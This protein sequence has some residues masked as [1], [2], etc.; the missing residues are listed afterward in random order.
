MIGLAE[1]APRDLPPKDS[2]R[3]LLEQSGRVCG[4]LH[5]LFHSLWWASGCLLGA[6]DQ[7]RPL[8][9]RV[10][11]A[12]LSCDASLGESRR[13]SIAVSFLQLCS[14]RKRR[15]SGGSAGREPRL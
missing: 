1:K 4:A 6:A 14:V 9:P 8:Q 5:D 13:V 15:P 2:G 12:G 7:K 10:S 11:S 3:F